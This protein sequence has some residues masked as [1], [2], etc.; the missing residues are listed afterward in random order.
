M[1]A[2]TARNK[3]DLYRNKRILR[4][5]DLSLEKI[6]EE[7]EIVCETGLYK[8]HEPFK[9]IISEVIPFLTKRLKDLGFKVEFNVGDDGPSRPGHDEL[10][11]D[12]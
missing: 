2:I 7:V 11:W 4:E 1:D 3:S 8:L 6:L 5:C 9:G 12:D 10:R